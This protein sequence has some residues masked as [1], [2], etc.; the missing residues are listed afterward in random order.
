M[1][2]RLDAENPK[3]EARNPKQ[4][5]MTKIQMVKTTVLNIETLGHSDLFRISDFDIRI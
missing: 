2:H 4:Y 3:S 1:I 5:R